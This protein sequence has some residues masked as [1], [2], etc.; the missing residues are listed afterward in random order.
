[1]TSPTPRKR[2]GRINASSWINPLPLQQYRKFTRFSSF[3]K[4]SLHKAGK[5]AKIMLRAKYFFCVAVICI[6]LALLFAV[7]NSSFPVPSKGFV[8]SNFRSKKWRTNSKS[9]T[10]RGSSSA[11]KQSSIDYSYINLRDNDD[12]NA[13]DIYDVVIVG[14]GPGKKKSH[15]QMT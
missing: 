8:F 9:I 15:N 1:M 11:G 7:A 3:E 14:C 10:F 5:Y 12:D 13:R 6:S 4:N 2:R